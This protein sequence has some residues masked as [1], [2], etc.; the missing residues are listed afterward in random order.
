MAPR[1]RNNRTHTNDDEGGAAHGSNVPHGE[2]VLGFIQRVENLNLDIAKEK[3]AMMTACKGIHTD[4]KEVFKEAKAAGI[5]K[6]ALKGHVKRRA[7]ERDIEDIRDD[8]EG[9]D[10]DSFDA[11]AIALQKI[12]DGADRKAA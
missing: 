1:V 9:D 6:K 5:N 11:L 2:Q 7:L 3:S 10:Q 8:L 12:A 4:I